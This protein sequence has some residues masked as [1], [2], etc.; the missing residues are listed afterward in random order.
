MSME[1]FDVISNFMMVGEL[2]MSRVGFVWLPFS[3]HIVPPLQKVACINR[4]HDG[5]SN[6]HSITQARESTNGN[7]SSRQASSICYLLSLGSVDHKNRS[8]QQHG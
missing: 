6:L 1:L 2:H 8:I 5:L 7:T 4:L 3:F